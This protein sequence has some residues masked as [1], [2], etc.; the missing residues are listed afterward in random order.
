MH[1]AIRREVSYSLR[2]W[3]VSKVFSCLRMASGVRPREANERK[4]GVTLTMGFRTRKTPQTGGSAGG[5]RQR[6]GLRIAVNVTAAFVVN[7]DLVFG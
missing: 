4:E 6:V 5:F 2:L 3:L 7:G 1:C